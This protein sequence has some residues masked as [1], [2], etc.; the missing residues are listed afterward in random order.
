[1]STKKTAALGKGLEAL[2]G[3]ISVA[4]GGLQSKD[5]K[6]HTV[7]AE[8][9][10]IPLDEISPN[11]DQP[12]KDFNEQTLEELAQSIK[13]HGVITPITVNKK[14]GKYIII[15]GE[16]RYRASKMAGLKEIPAYIRI[17]TLQETMEMSLIENIQRED[18]NSIEI[19]LSLQAL[20]QET[21]LTQEELS[22]KL[23]KSRGTISN[24]I[25]L[26][27]L[28]AEVQMALRNDEITMGHARSIITIEDENKQ[29]EIV[30]EIKEKD[31]SVRQVENW[32][33][34]LKQEQL[35]EKAIK[36][37]SK[38]DLPLT[39]IEVKRN[40]AKQLSTEIEIKRSLRGKGSINIS[41]SNDKEFERIVAILQKSQ[42]D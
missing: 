42:K 15:A 27:K 4:N 29:V 24:Y 37:T 3:N 33:L 23:G 10:Y 9:A 21:N 32:A 7:T 16:R 36:R 28:P 8:I 39:H 38:S 20:L 1:M 26:L 25:R 41:F 5:K 19:A 11:P 17:V 13:E 18:L 22:K 40:L 6:T 34:R 31:L 30:R 14:D 2:L 35:S 12:R